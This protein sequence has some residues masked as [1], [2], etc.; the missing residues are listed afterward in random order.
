MPNA[1]QRDMEQNLFDWHHFIGNGHFNVTKETISTAVLIVTMAL[2]FSVLYIYCSYKWLDH[3]A[4]VEKITHSILCRG[5]KFNEFAGT[6]IIVIFPVF[7][8]V[9]ILNQSR[10]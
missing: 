5:D 3:L 9:F 1:V 2:L 4:R 6:I 7:V 8:F 10:K